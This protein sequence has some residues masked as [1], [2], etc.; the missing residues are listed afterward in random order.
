M[1]G[2]PARWLQLPLDLQLVAIAWWL[3]FCLR[4]NQVVNATRSATSARP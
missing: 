4:F 3:V 2:T 1:M